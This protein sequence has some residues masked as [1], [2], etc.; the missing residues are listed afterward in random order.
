[1]NIKI[2]C[3]KEKNVGIGW[4][5]AEAT[6]VIFNMEPQGLEKPR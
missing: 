4:H 5:E 2:Y 1:M 6:L 3:K